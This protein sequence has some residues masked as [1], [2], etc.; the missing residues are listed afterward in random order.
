MGALALAL[1]IMGMLMPAL[2]IIGISTVALITGAM[3]A[4]TGR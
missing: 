4:F 3:L 2:P 1:G